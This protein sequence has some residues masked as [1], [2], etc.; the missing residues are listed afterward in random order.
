MI[1]RYFDVEG[2]KK[3]KRN[4]K[5]LF[6]IHPKRTDPNIPMKPVDNMFLDFYLKQ[7][8]NTTHVNKQVS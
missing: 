8:K 7:N 4:T 3:P 2:I 6:L 5:D 1:N